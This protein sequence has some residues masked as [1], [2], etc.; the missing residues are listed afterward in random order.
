M[1]LQRKE[2][3]Q[4]VS[5]DCQR[6]LTSAVDMLFVM[7]KTVDLG[8]AAGNCCYTN[9]VYILINF[10]KEKMSKYLVLNH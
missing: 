1:L 3:Q 9:A 5:V 2:D 10:F 4:H 7:Q 8:V 6:M